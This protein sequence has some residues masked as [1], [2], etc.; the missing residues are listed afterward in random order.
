MVLNKLIISLSFQTSALVRDSHDNWPSHIHK[1]WIIQNPNRDGLVEEPYLFS[2][3]LVYQTRRKIILCRSCRFGIV[4]GKIKDHFKE[5]HKDIMVN[6]EQINKVTTPL[7]IPEQYPEPWTGGWTGGIWWIQMPWLHQGERV[8][9][10]IKK[11]APGR[12]PR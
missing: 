6:T 12:S 10:Y 11:N 8:K 2:L 5:R 4:P 7:N 3:G 1:P 9:R